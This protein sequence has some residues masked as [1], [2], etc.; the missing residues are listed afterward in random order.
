VR[1]YVF[2]LARGWGFLPAR[3]SAVPIDVR[4]KGRQDAAAEM[5]SIAAQSFNYFDKTF[6]PYI[7]AHLTVLSTVYPT[8]GEEYPTLVFIDN[9]RDTAYRRFITTHEVAHQWFYGIAGNDIARHAWLDESLAQISL[10]LFY[11]DTYGKDVAEREWQY[12]LTWADRLKEA[13][14]PIDTAVESFANFN[15]YMIHNYGLGPV[16]LRQIGEKIGWGRFKAGL[17]A[18]FESAQLQLG[19]PTMFFTAIQGQAPEIDLAPLFC[20]KLGTNCKPATP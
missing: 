16:F 13:A 5:A 19:T 9:Q 4:Y 2:Q 17:A 7:Y 3:G 14:K 18:Y 8:G 1:D 6:G 11:L 15:E 12:I 20:A 10:Y